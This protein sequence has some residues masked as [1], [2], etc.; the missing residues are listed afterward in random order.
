MGTDLK[1]EQISFVVRQF[2]ALYSFSKDDAIR[3][4]SKQSPIHFPRWL[5]WNTFKM[6]HWKEN[7]KSS[8]LRIYGN[9]S[10]LAGRS[11]TEIQVAKVADKNPPLYLR[12]SWCH[13]W[14][15][16]FIKLLIMPLY[17]FKGMWAI[18]ST[19]YIC[20]IGHRTKK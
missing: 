20:P 18:S 6:G 3:E 17:L 8:P 10:F 15:R 11:G 16:D 1:F 9:K 7:G 12:V 5:P 13:R 4:N 19:L 2:L 14:R